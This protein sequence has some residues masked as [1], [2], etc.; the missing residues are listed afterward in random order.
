MTD[1]AI[2]GVVPPANEPLTTADGRPL[3]SALARAERMRRVKAMLLVLPL[4]LFIGVSFLFPIALMLFRSV[5][6]PLVADHMPRTVAALEAWDDRSELPNEAVYAALVADLAEAREDRT[7]GRLATRLNYETGGLRSTITRTGRRAARLEPPFKEALIGLNDDW[8]N[9]ETFATIKRL[10]SRL[11]DVQYLA[12]VD[13]RYD[14]NDNIVAQPEVRQ[15]YVSN[16]IQTLWM[17]IIVTVACLVLG[18]PVAY[19]LSILPL[20]YSNVLMILVLLPFWTSLLVRTT[21]WIVLLQTEGIINDILVWIGIL[22]DDGRI[23]LIF[24]AEGTVIAMTQILLPFMI[25]PLYSVMK[26]IP[27]SY[28]RAAMSLGANRYYAFWRVYAPNT[29]PG[30]GA[31]C[32]LVFILAIGYY[33]T[34][35]LVGGQDGMMISNFIA[36]HMQR[37]LNWGLAAALG[38][39]L[40]LG[41]LILYWVYNKLVGIERLKLG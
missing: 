34:P 29:L 14:V 39:I 3:K 10:G 22:S 26:T 38:T 17:S 8:A 15:I 18:Y 6:N 13:R 41:V 31:G 37:S 35:A 1:A 40:L 30:V 9:P 19:L 23:Q 7:I 20:R 36:Y 4:L 16:F 27:P 25:L 5:D 32:L 28:M 33:I 12:A 2:T 21:S 11:T 24:N